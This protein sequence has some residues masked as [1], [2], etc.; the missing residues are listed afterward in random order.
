MAHALILMQDRQPSAI[1]PCADVVDDL[2]KRLPGDAKPATSPLP[3]FRLPFCP[4]NGARPSAHAVAAI[5]VNCDEQDCVGVTLRPPLCRI[6]PP[7][8]EP[9]V[10]SLV[11]GQSA[12]FSLLD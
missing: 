9:T 5:P 12:L 2:R 3:Q 11:T 7:F 1:L 8:N 6:A 4:H 10:T